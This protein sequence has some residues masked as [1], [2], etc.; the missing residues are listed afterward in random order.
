VRARDCGPP[1][2][3]AT[4]LRGSSLA[5]DPIEVVPVMLVELVVDDVEV[6]APTGVLLDGGPS[7]LTGP[8]DEEV[9]AVD[10]VRAVDDLPAVEGVAP[11]DDVEEESVVD[12]SVGFAHATPGV[13]ATA[14]PT[15]KATAKPPTRPTYLA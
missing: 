6:D 8:V 11:V 14:T 3:C 5:V 13:V 9:V 12:E 2:L 1:L 15:P 4:P 7:D 10:A